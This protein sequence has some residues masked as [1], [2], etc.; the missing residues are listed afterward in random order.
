MP[1]FAK[2]KL[3]V[4]QFKC[5]E[6][7]QRGRFRQLGQEFS[8]SSVR[9]V[10]TGEMGEIGGDAFCLGDEQRQEIKVAVAKERKI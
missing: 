7:D 1:C 5:V 3:F 10:E 2:S 9:T 6:T 8:V 4:A